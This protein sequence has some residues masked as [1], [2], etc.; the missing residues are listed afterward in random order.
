MKIL[1]IDTTTR[2]LCIGLFDGTKIYEYRLELG[3]RQSTLLVPTIKRILTALKWKLDDLDYFACGVGPGSFTGIR[4][5][6]ST[7][8]GFSWI[9]RKPVIGVPSLDLLAYNAI[10]FDADIVSI[11]DAKR[12]LIYFC[13]YKNRHGN[14][15]R[16][17]DYQ[18]LSK[19]ELLKKIK[20]GS[21]LVGDALGL[22]KEELAKTAGGLNLLNKDYW[23]PTGRGIINI[24][25]EKIKHKE[26]NTCFNIEPIYLYPDAC[27]VKKAQSVK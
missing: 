15:K 26:V 5:G 27:Q 23:Y 6:L 8:K 13:T 10:G 12:S 20:P 4:V 18:L 1:G 19:E 2:F 9:T 14:I 17:S 3:T 21:I 24:A 11:I 22:Y 7:I 16:A 25:L